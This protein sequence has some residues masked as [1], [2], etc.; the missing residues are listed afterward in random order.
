MITIED[1]NLLMLFTDGSVNTKLDIGY[2][3]YLLVSENKMFPD[4]LR[5]KVKLKRF[6]E[7][8][9]VKLELQTLLWAL[10]EVRNFNGKI[11][12]YTD[13][14][15]ILGLAGRRDR[16]EKSDFYSKQNRRINNWEL[17]R[18]FYLLTDD[19]NI[20]VKKVTGHKKNS[21]KDYIDRLFTLVDRASRK[22]L[23]EEKSKEC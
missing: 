12:V 18:D 7:T 8:N 9:S 6:D 17:Y 21:T 11:D 20:E 10:N 16:L 14:Q 23:R 19:M 5:N 3:A 2:G 4:V 15:N 13:S 22:A 1:S